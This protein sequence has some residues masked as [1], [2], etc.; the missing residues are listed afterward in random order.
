MAKEKDTTLTKEERRAARKAEKEKKR[1]ATDGVHK[2]KDKKEK[3]KDRAALVEKVENALGTKPVDKTAE[4]NGDTE[5]EASG[6]EDENNDEKAVPLRPKK[7]VGALVPFA[8][9]L[10]DEKT[11]KKIFRGVKKGTTPTGTLRDRRCLCNNILIFS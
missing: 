7:P 4:A 11:A 6:S 2:T 10:V 9:P 3:K 1:S 5:D 8:N